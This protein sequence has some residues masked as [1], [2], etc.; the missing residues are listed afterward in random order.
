[1]PIT[2]IHSATRS[3]AYQALNRGVEKGDHGFYVKTPTDAE[4]KV[5]N[6]AKRQAKRIVVKIGSSSLVKDGRPN[7]DCIQKLAH[8]VSSARKSGK[9]VT[10]VASGA[11]ALGK[12]RMGMPANAQVSLDRKQVLAG[13]G[14]PHLI[15]ALDEEFRTQDPP[16][17][18]CMA[19]VSDAEMQAATNGLHN[20]TKTQM[21]ANEMN[22]VMVINANDVTCR[23]QLSGQSGDNDNLAVK[24]ATRLDSDMVILFSDIYGLHTSKPDMDNP[25]PTTPLICSMSDKTIHDYKQGGTGS[26]S[27][28]GTGGG[29]SKYQ[30]AGEAMDT[31]RTMVVTKSGTSYESLFKLD[32][33]GNSTWFTSE[34]TAEYN[35]FKVQQATVQTQEPK[36]VPSA[37]A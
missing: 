6:D 19:L 16:F 12:S 34:R 35:A 4:I 5:I 27:A 15:T 10:V 37:A 22:V 8:F 33:Y 2:S 9:E 25:S 32:S 28:H 14:Q 13:V 21:A 24:I 36:T 31:G 20:L 18:A 23:F 26:G 17:S 30:A 3:D 1:M 11:V 29:A 7:K